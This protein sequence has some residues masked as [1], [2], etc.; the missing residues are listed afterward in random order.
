MA[1]VDCLDFEFQDEGLAKEVFMHTLSTEYPY[2]AMVMKMYL[3]EL[4][5]I[6]PK[7]RTFDGIHYY[8]DDASKRD[9]YIK[10]CVGQADDESMQVSEDTCDKIRRNLAKL[11]KKEK[12][13]TVSRE[14]AVDL[15]RFF[16]YQDDIPFEV[17]ENG[18]FAR[19]HSMN[20]LLDQMGIK[21]KKIFLRR[22]QDRPL[23]AKIPYTYGRSTEYAPLDNHVATV[24]TV[25]GK[26]NK[27]QDVVLDPALYFKPMSIERWKSEM[28]K[29][30]CKMTSNPHKAMANKDC[31]L[32]ITEDTNFYDWYVPD[33]DKKNEKETFTY[34]SQK[35]AEKINQ[36]ELEGLRVNARIR[37][38]F[39]GRIDPISLNLIPIEEK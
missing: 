6:C 1:N 15:M 10:A 38:K 36:E 3:L 13:E 4:Q 11:G 2:E 28:T 7:C 23:L 31:S 26:D 32:F 29:D 22:G 16:L 34:Y 9:M 25:K 27:T 8:T 5:L 30:K 21:S 33:P 20:H 24:V 14:Q 18:C 12:Q 35:K 39:S 37:R 19:A 17:I